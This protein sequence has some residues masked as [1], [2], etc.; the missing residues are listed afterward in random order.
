HIIDHVYMG[1]LGISEHDGRGQE[2]KWKIRLDN[3]H[4]RSA[5][6]YFKTEY[7]LTFSDKVMESVKDE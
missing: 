6:I 4:N 2:G 1:I 3:G 5:E 7:A